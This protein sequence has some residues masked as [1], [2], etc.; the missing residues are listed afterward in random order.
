MCV[1]AIVRHGDRTPKQK[2]KFVTQEP[3]LLSLVEEFLPKGEDELKM[4]NVSEARSVAGRF[5]VRSLFTRS[6]ATDRL[7]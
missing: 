5:L 2:L 7:V 1:V 3:E 6:R 4:K